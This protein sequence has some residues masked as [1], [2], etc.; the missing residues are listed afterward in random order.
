MILACRVVESITSLSFGRESSHVTGSSEEIGKAVAIGISQAGATVLVTG[1]K[2]ECTKKVAEEVAQ[3]TGRE[4]D[5]FIGD[6]SKDE[7]VIQ[8]VEK[9]IHKW[10]K[11]DI[12]VN[13]AGGGV[14]L[15][16]LEQTPEAF[17]TTIDRNLWTL[18]WSCYRV[19]PHMVKPK[20]R[21]EY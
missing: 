13:N 5:Y 18:L 19:L 15:P 9:A 10:D 1:T 17:K 8:M 16:F 6:L 12:L 20:L 2:P 3:L 21:T 14:I 11:I 4:T 7:N